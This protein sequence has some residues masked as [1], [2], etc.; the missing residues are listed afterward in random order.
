MHWFT[1]DY[2]AQR[3]REQRSGTLV[4]RGFWL[5]GIPR[6]IP[7][8]RLWGHRPVVD[9]TP[10]TRPGHPGSRWVCCD[11]CGT[12]PDP[13]GNL[14]P[15][16]WNIGDRYTGPWR[17]PLPHLQPHRREELTSLKGRTYAPG[18]WPSKPKGEIGGQL[19]VGRTLGGAGIELKVGCA[20][21]EQTLAG[22]LRLHHLGALHLHTQGF[23]QWLQRR[24]I[25]TGYD[26]RV[27]ELYVSNAA[28]T[29]RLWTKRN[30]W[31]SDTPRWR[32]GWVSLDVRDWLWGS[33]TLEIQNVGEARPAIVRLPEGDEHEVVL[34]LKR[35]I[36][37]R[38]RRPRRTTQTW[39]VNWRCAEGIACRNDDDGSQ[40]STLHG[41]QEFVSEDA[42]EAGT[43]PSEALASMITR[44]MGQQ[45]G[46]GM[47]TAQAPRAP[48]R[49]GIA[50]WR[51][52]CG[53]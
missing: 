3:P 6:L 21:S 20:G 46:N 14:D 18:P 52:V 24:L 5:N 43:W 2:L 8:C 50:E 28:L 4:D 12:R 23:G 30:E 51:V 16:E 19:I 44:V 13:Q 38:P 45:V 31:S 39:V 40:G 33:S 15:A 11:R 1:A 36:T 26:S 27:I 53:G 37:R 35:W 47:S 22:S 9:G 48:S 29:W 34:Q 49:V 41:A 10:E 17:P 42:A 32:E 25:P 7:R